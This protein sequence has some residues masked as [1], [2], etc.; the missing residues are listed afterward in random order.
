[1]SSLESNVVSSGQD[2]GKITCVWPVHAFMK[3]IIYGVCLPYPS[4]GMQSHMQACGCMQS[5]VAGF[6]HGNKIKSN[7]EQ[8]KKW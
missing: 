3:L 7:L 6:P 2:I 5:W 1:M 8:K 4:T